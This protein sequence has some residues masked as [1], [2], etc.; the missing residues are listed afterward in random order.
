MTG[1]VAMFNGQIWAIFIT[2]AVIL[3]ASF[4]CLS[5]ASRYTHASNVSLLMLLETVLAP[6][7]VWWGVGEAPTT[8][9]IIGGAVVIGSLGAYLMYMRRQAMRGV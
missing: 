8:N 4:F 1:P 6:I 7:W 9:M 2:G 3:P 5:L